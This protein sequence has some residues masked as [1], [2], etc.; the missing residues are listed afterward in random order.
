[1]VNLDRYSTV[2]MWSNACR[3]QEGSPEFEQKQLTVAMLEAPNAYF[4]LPLFYLL[5][6]L[7]IFDAICI[8]RAI[9]TIP[10]TKKGTETGYMHLQLWTIH[11]NPPPWRIQPLNKKISFRSKRPP[12]SNMHNL[13][14]TTS[15]AS[16]MHPFLPSFLPSPQACCR[17]NA[18]PSSP[19][20]SSR[21]PR[22]TPIPQRWWKA[23]VKPRSPL[24][25]SW[26]SSGE[27]GNTVPSISL[28]SKWAYCDMSWLIFFPLSL[29]SILFIFL[30]KFLFYRAFCARMNLNGT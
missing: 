25:R 12:K 29:L 23:K 15:I 2:S 20:P 18:L 21:P 26:W 6:Y 13:L 27:L 11:E 19:S 9:H 10:E 3:E 7:L 17:E 4:P 22:P 5:M 1:M 30:L 8:V 14:C 24:G 28:T 16:D